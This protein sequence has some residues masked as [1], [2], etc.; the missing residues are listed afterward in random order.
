MRKLRYAEVACSTGRKEL[1]MGNLRQST[2]IIERKD[3]QCV[4]LCPGLDIGSQGASVE[5]A[6]WN[7]EE[8]LE[9]F[10]KTASQGE[11]RERLHEEVFVTGWR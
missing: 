9:V 7:L 11:I 3:D 10:F 2:A 6:R 5:E 4:T 8:A 1:D